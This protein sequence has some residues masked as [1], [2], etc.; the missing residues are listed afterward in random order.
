MFH[1]KNV[2]DHECFD[3]FLMFSV[4]KCS[5]KPWQTHQTKTPSSTNVHFG[6]KHI[7]PM[8]EDLLPGSNLERSIRD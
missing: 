8:F 6:K 5:G 7:P 3:V 2:M 1:G 4:L